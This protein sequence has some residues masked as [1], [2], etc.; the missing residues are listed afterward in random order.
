METTVTT[1]QQIRY[2]EERKEYRVAAMMDKFGQNAVDY[3]SQYADL[4]HPGTEVLCTTESFNVQAV[5]ARSLR[6]FVNLKRVND[7]QNP[8]EFFALVNQKLP[9]GGYFIGCV[10]TIASRKNRILNKHH[11]VIS[12]PYYL[13]DFIVKRVFPK[14]K[15]TRRIYSFLTRGINRTMSVTETLGRL[16]VCGFEV[17]DRQ[18]IGYLTYFVC[19]KKF[20]PVLNGEASYGFLIGLNRMGKNGKLFKVY[21]FRTMHPYAEFIQDYVYINNDLQRNGKFKD[22]FR[23][24]SWGRI[25]RK[26]WLDEQAMWLNWLKRDMKL[27]GVRPLSAH[28]FGLYPEE[29]QKRRM[30]YKPGLIPPFYVDLPKTLEEIIA[31]E[32][33]YL[34][35]Y[36]K[37]PWLTDFRYFWKAFYNIA[38]KGARSG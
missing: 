36:D 29:F 3:I 26:L 22:D 25:L 9:D 38:I 15:P 11:P 14:I 8:N 35:A 16:A 6:A 21:K 5:N 32:Q 4:A 18:E 23:I 17:V 20:V 1:S 34:D 31:S 7:I 13:I 19:K 33:K 10:E 24:T 28:Y 37:H 2:F 30:K 27:V 12:Y